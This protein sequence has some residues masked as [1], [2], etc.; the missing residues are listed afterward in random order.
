MLYVNT[1]AISKAPRW[2]PCWA[3]R[4]VQSVNYTHA[5]RLLMCWT[6]ETRPE[7]QTGVKLDCYH[8]KTHDPLEALSKRRASNAPL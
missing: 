3:E 1:S 7:S 8:D 2:F 6:S 4:I 5:H